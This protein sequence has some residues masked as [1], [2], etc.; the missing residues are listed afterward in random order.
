MRDSSRE[1]ATYE[2]SHGLGLVV[3]PSDDPE[4]ELFIEETIHKVCILYVDVL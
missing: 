1:H 3:L 4:T 2:L